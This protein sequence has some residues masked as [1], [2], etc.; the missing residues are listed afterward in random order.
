I[1]NP[2][3]KNREVNRSLEKIFIP[4]LFRSLDLALDTYYDLKKTFL[5]LSR[6]H[7]EFLCLIFIF[8]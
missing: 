3:R 2:I 5:A 4:S 6:A 8:N 7:F 1:E